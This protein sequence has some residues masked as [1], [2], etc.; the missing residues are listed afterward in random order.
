VGLHKTASTYL[1]NA[2]FPRYTE[3]IQYCHPRYTHS[4]IR[5]LTT[6]DETIY[7]ICVADTWIKELY[8]GHK[9]FILSSE[10]LS[11]HPG[12]KY[13]NRTMIFQRL[14]GL[15]P[16]AKVIIGLRDHGGLI[17]SMYKLYVQNGG[18]KSFKNYVFD[19]QVQYQN[20][21]YFGL[22]NRIELQ[23][24]SYSVILDQLFKLFGKTNVHVFNFN[25]FVLDNYAEINR[26]SEFIGFIGDIDFPKETVNKSISWPEVD[27]LRRLN[28]FSRSS[29][30]EA[31][32]INRS[33]WIF[34]LL[35][36]V[37]RQSRNNLT[38]YNQFL[39]I[40]GSEPF[41]KDTQL[42]KEKFGIEFRQTLKGNG[43]I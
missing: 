1:Q 4:L 38:S 8:S 35:K 18:T 28:R 31:G 12:I 20:E 26:L 17:A 32:I 19:E 33:S 3:H 34:N 15:F 2:V 43:N 10:N 30:H 37:L 9:P 24:F 6:T 36:K 11:G 40:M 25:E 5:Y 39:E 22:Y 21:S 42:L 16:D 41:R 29:Y 23:M 7:N 14:K 13:M 27:Y